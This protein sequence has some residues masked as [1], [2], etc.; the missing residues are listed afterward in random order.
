[1]KNGAL[2]TYYCS[3]NHLIVILL[4]GLRQSYPERILDT[5]VPF[6]TGNILVPFSELPTAY[7]GLCWLC[8]FIFELPIDLSLCWSAYFSWLFLRLFMVTKGQAPGQVGDQ[9][10]SFALVTFFP[11]RAAPT[12]EWMGKVA[13]KFANLCKLIDAVQSCIISQKIK[14]AKAK[15]EDRKKAL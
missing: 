5:F 2:D 12:V 6:I 10:A 8:S 11:E 9:S 14:S 3:I 1:M 15:A 4:M 13:F 7:V